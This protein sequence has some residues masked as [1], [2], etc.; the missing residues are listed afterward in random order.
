MLINNPVVTAA[1]LEMRD[2][3]EVFRVMN[4]FGYECS[5][6]DVIEADIVCDVNDFKVFNRINPL[7]P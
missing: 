2:G 3:I 7:C 1:N 5:F 4:V 6:Y